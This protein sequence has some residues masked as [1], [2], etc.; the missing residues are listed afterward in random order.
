MFD[1]EAPCHRKSFYKEK[2]YTG[3]K[4][5][6][7]MIMKQNLGIMASLLLVFSTHGIVAQ[8]YRLESPNKNISVTVDHQKSLSF[9]VGMGGKPVLDKSTISLILNGVE[10]GGSPRLR[11]VEKTSVDETIRPVVRQ[12]S[13][14]IRNNY[15]QLQ[16]FYKGNYSVTFRAFDDGIAY[17]FETNEKNEVII[18]DELLKLNF[19]GPTMGYLPLEESL[20][21]HYERTYTHTK[22]D[23]LDT[24]DFCSLPVL[25][26]S[27]G[28]NVLVTETDLYDYPGLFLKGN[29]GQS[30]KSH[31]PKYVT[32]AVASDNRPDR[33]QVLTEADY[34]AKT[35]GSR[36]FPWRIFIVSDE[37]ATLLRTQLPY[38]LARDSDQ[39]NTDW[40]Q[41]GKV[42]WDWYNKNNVYGVNFEAG[43]NN[44][45]YKYY[46]DFASEYG[47]EYVILDEGWTKSTT[48]IGEYAENIDVEQLVAYGKEKNVGIIIWALWGPLDKNLEPLLERYSSWGVKGIKVDFMQRADQYMVKFYERVAKAAWKNQLLVNFHGA[49]KPAGLSRAYPNVITYEG[50]FG[51]EQ[52]K[53]NNKLTPEH[54][55]L[56]PFTRMVAGPMDYTPGAMVSAN[57]ENHKVI[58]NKP[59]SMNTRAHQMAMYAIYES[60]LQMLCASPTDYRKEPELTRLIAQIPTVWDETKVLE[61]R[62]G[63]YVVLAR[64]SG[65]VWYIGALTDEK[66][67]NFEIDFSFLDDGNYKVVIVKDG[68]NAARHAE[69][70]AIQKRELSKN[71]HLDIRL[72][73]GGGWLAIAKPDII[74]ET[75]KE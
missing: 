38:V 58:F 13:A 16:L 72:A 26:Q 4:T 66:A 74:T 2:T 45:T 55:V 49:F 25:L 24:E 22:L 14:E 9:S 70:Y 60:P 56:L 50:V 44:Y 47:L 59:M 19:A 46:I 3:A 51:N 41:P 6:K 12:K 32:Q 31:F 29:L 63:D 10:L 43:I 61:A 65:Q 62:A 8:S 69:D 15:N 27:N 64:R 28:T 39:K 1:R 21:S 40:I 75:P 57:P 48:E 54:N 33:N 35:A 73:A 30:L 18:E 53:F 68:V 36:T 20:I 71:S 11:R 5:A 37:D 23:T 67:R 7:R 17:R 34:I 52:N 42:A